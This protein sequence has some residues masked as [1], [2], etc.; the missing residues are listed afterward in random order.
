MHIKVQPAMLV[1]IIKQAS[2][3]NETNYNIVSTYIICT[4][5]AHI[6]ETKQEQNL[7]NISPKPV[8]FQ[9]DYDNENLCKHCFIRKTI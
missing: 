1:A 8:L 4:Y 3:S 9:G 5:T 2:Y 7:H 6:H